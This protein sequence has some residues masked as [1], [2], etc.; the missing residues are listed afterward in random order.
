MG[1]CGCASGVLAVALA[2]S[3]RRWYIARARTAAGSL[4]GAFGSLGRAGTL[5]AAARAAPWLPG[6]TGGS[7]LDLAAEGAPAAAVVLTLFAPC[8]ITMLDGLLTGV[9]GAALGVTASSL[10]PTLG[11]VAFKGG[12]FGGVA[13]AG[14]PAAAAAAAGL[15]CAPALALASDAASTKAGMLG[16]RGRNGISTFSGDLDLAAM[17]LLAH[18]QK[19]DDPF[20]SD[21]RRARKAKFHPVSLTEKCAVG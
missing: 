7:G 4:S 17:E 19:S 2:S 20:S 10:G 11:V 1:C 6:K 12:N 3:E 13:G 5:E 9:E 8:T 15:G 21:S 16:G 18:D 14:I